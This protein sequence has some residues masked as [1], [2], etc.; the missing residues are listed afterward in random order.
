MKEHMN[1]PVF[2]PHLGCGHSCAFCSQ[3][4]VTNVQAAPSPESVAFSVREMLSTRG[5]KTAEIAFFG[6]S[7]T[8][9]PK[10]E[11]K[12]YLM[13]VQPFLERG[14]AESIRVST[15]PDYI[16]PETVAFLKAYG[17]KTVELGAQSMSDKVLAACNR[18][19]T[20]ADTAYAA[21]CI[22]DGGLT[23]GLQMMTGLP[24]STKEDEAYTASCFVKL[25]ASIARIYP[26]VVFYDTPLYQ[27]MLMG[28][29]TPPSEEET[30]DRAAKALSILE[31]GGVHVI[32]I[33]L[34]ETETLGQKSAGGAY[35]PAMGEK[36]R[37]RV[38]RDKTEK[39]ILLL[40]GNA[41]ILQCPEK[42]TSRLLGHK[43]ENILYL[44]EKYK[45]KL[46]LMRGESCAVSDGKNKVA[47]L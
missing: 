10:E 45:I 23:L 34:Q 37:A 18:G 5:R 38:L 29:Y 3:R 25:G 31:D 30:V 2:I 6:G 11:Q 4:S 8:G 35:H 32:R 21:D 20:A 15:R 28:E 40:S 19:H 17:V 41:F 22:H 1:V 7:F 39:A 27:S 14:E 16:D 36:I 9:I 12:A 26:T 46:T 47:L 43:R 24:L 42:M 33:G 44:E 13:A